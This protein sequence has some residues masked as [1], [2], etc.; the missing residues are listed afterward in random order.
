MNS[1]G[2]SSRSLASCQTAGSPFNGPAFLRLR[3]FS[4]PLFGI[5]KFNNN[6][7]P[8][9]ISITKSPEKFESSKMTRFSEK[10]SQRHKKCQI[11]TA[12]STLWDHILTISEILKFLRRRRIKKKDEI[13]EMQFGILKSSKSRANHVPSYIPFRET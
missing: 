7:F 3:F 9:K 4:I 2:A 11:R 6:N 1:L 8:V 13:V 12:V 10:I 5:R